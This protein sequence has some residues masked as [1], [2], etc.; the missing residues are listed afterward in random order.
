MSNFEV[1]SSLI[2]I[3]AVVLSSI[4]LYRSRKT[5]T[6]LLEFEEIHVKLSQKQLEEY[7]L[8]ELKNFKT[9]IELKLIDGKFVMKNIGEHSASNIYFSLTQDNQHN[10]LISYD[11][12]K[13]YHSLN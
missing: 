12:D 2:S 6:K 11:F 8:R 9:D 13:K 3:L 1:I 7:E 4:A 10:P 5:Q